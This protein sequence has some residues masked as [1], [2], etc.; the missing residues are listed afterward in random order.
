M[1]SEDTIGGGGVRRDKESVEQRLTR[2]EESLD[3][4]QAS[5][6][7]LISKINTVK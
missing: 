2:C 3:S 4:C 7:E 6:L 1:K 5:I